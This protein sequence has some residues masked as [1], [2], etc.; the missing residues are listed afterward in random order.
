[1]IYNWREG[2]ELPGTCPGYGRLFDANGKQISQYV[3]WADTETGQVLH[4][5]RDPDGVW[6]IEND[7][8]KSEELYYEPPLRFEEMQPGEDYFKAELASPVLF[9]DEPIRI[10]IDGPIVMD[11]TKKDDKIES[12]NCRNREYRTYEP[13][14]TLGE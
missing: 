7:E 10:G 9:S 1:M 11:T 2:N 13:A 14:K 6:I 5:L 3:F 12:T 4:S 8:I